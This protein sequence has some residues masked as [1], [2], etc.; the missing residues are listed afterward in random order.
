MK[1]FIAI[2]CLAVLCYGNQVVMAAEAQPTAPAETTQAP[3]GVDF[4]SLTNMDPQKIWDTISHYLATQGMDLL[5]R[6]ITAALIFYVGRWLARVLTNL[7]ENV[8]NRAKVDPTLSKFVRNLLYFGL[9]VFVA[10]AAL[11]RLGVETTS[12]V[13]VIGAAGLAVGLAL[14]GSLSNFAAGVLLIIF[15]PFRVGDFVEAAG[16]SGTVQEIQIFNTVL[17]SPDNVRIIIPNSQVTGANIINY[18]A[19]DKRRVDLVIGISY[20]DDIGKAKQVITSVLLSDRRVLRDP[21][22][23]V[24]V[25]GL[26]DSSVN[27][28]VRPWVKVDD[29]WPT[30]F[31]LMENIKVSLEQNGLSIPFP[32]QDIHIRT[33]SL[34]V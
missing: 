25:L 1:C 6:L 13:A 17:H 34:K 28:A 32:Q 3:S 30:Y 7:L 33:G 4:S 5:F 15:K 16:A 20:E 12:L 26:A 11:S 23:I 21:E 24:A 18:T 19:N 8:L 31:D 10:I 29:Y 14:Q 27:I 2:F 22:P 9:L